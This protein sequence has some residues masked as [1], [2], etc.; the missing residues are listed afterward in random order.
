MVRYGPH[1]HPLALDTI[2]IYWKNNFHFCVMNER[3]NH[4]QPVKPKEKPHLSSAAPHLWFPQSHTLQNTTEKQRNHV[5][6]GNRCQNNLAYLVNTHFIYGTNQNCPTTSFFLL[7]QVEYCQT[8]G[9][10][11]CDTGGAN[12]NIGSKKGR[13]VRREDTLLTLWV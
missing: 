10:N 6:S 3:R 8:R 5:W 7:F 2:K 13:S 4:M 1:P 11:I 9:N 12:M